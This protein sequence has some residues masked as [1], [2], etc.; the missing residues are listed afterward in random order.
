MVG[1]PTDAAVM[2]SLTVCV[3]PQCEQKHSIVR[4]LPS[5][6]YRGL[7]HVL[8]VTDE[9]WLMNHT[10]VYS[11]SSFT[12][13]SGKKNVLTAHVGVRQQQSFI[14]FCCF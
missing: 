6:N 5:L 1:T 9:V 2:P 8:R 12:L 14:F 11:T 10:Q 7:L 3:F 13:L 4:T